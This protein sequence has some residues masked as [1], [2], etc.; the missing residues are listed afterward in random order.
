MD[1]WAQ[2]I[3]G[4]LVGGYLAWMVL[5][6]GLKIPEI[7]ESSPWEVASVLVIL[8]AF[9]I[10][11]YYIIKRILGD[12]YDHERA[13]WRMEMDQVLWKLDVAMRARGVQV[14]VERKGDR[15]WFPLPPLSI[16]VAPGWRRTRIYVGPSTNETDILVARLE[17][18]VER[19]LG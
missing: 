5:G 16:V 10:V 13:F 3:A 14:A 4:Y 18:F 8:I 6:L 17:T 9:S 15:V 2:P 12:L 19:A 1:R 11:Y 7:F